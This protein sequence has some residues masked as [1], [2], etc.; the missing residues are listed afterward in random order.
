MFTWVNL[1][2]MLISAAKAL[3]QWLHDRQMIQA[4]HD[5]AVAQA[6][7]ELLQTT[8]EGKRLREA[9]KAIETP[10]EEE[11]LWDAMLKHK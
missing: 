4:G 3:T 11:D 7:M 9:V 5:K 10:K 1:I 2:L 8:Q 6:A